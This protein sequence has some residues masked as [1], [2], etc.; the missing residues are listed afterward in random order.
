MVVQLFVNK[1]GL[2]TALVKV[3]GTVHQ[4]TT[5]PRLDLFQVGVFMNLSGRAFLLLTS[6]L[7]V[8][9]GRAP[10]PEADIQLSMSVMAKRLVMPRSK[11]SWSTM[12]YH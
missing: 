1:S 2:G 4:S 5:D 10:I 7:P 3:R 12:A 6:S 11:V 9:R 8:C